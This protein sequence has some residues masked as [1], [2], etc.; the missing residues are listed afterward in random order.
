MISADTLMHK[1]GPARCSVPGVRRM[2]E[3][4]KLRCV[5]TLNVNHTSGNGMKVLV[6]TGILWS[7]D[8][9]TANASH[10]VWTLQDTEWGLLRVG[11]GCEV[12]LR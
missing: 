7:K 6:S 11:Q 3:S 8:Q 10:S 12:M 9:A 4:N 5:T 2:A 1:C